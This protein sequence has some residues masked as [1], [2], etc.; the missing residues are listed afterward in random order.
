MRNPGNADRIPAFGGY[1][2]I[3][4]SPFS[5]QVKYATIS[6]G[7]EILE[8]APEWYQKNSRKQESLS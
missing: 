1:L 4:N 8:H 3:Y 6:K 2:I 7:S 5:F